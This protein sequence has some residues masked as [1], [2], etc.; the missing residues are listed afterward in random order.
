MGDGFLGPPIIVTAAELNYLKQ[1]ARDQPTLYFEPFM[2]VM[3]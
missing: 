2:A 3:S 1:I